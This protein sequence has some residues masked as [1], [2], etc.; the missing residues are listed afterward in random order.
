MLLVNLLLI[1]GATQALALTISPENTPSFQAR[2]AVV[3]AAGKPGADDDDAIAYAWF[4]EDEEP[5]KREVEAAGASGSDDD[6]A[7]AYAWFSE[8]EH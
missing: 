4:S 8:D 1:G 3:E 2:S 6:D 5:E 7:I